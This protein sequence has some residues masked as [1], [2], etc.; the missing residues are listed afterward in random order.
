MLARGASVDGRE[1]AGLDLLADLSL[2]GPFLL[3]AEMFVTLTFFSQSGGYSP[4]CQYHPFFSSSHS[5]MADGFY[6]LVYANTNLKGRSNRGLAEMTISSPSGEIREKPRLPTNFCSNE[7]ITACQYPC[8]AGVQ[9]PSLS[10]PGMVI[11]LKCYLQ[12]S[13]AVCHRKGRI[14]VEDSMRKEK[15]S[16]MS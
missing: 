13:K 15:S 10:E 12:N 11:A 3:G 7:V 14:E 1:V 5:K 2:A 6:F 8:M 16:G 4:V 9:R